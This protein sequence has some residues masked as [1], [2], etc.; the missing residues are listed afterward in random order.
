MVARVWG[1]FL[2]A[3][4]ND[5][6]KRNKVFGNICLSAKVEMIDFNPIPFIVLSSQQGCAIKASFL[7]SFKSFL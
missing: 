1:I 7:F 2:L 5:L 3:I 4:S 6:N